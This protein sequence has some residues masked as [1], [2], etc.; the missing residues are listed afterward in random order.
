VWWREVLRDAISRGP[1]RAATSLGDGRSRYGEPVDRCQLFAPWRRSDAVRLKLRLDVSRA[2]ARVRPSP[3]QTLG[4]PLVTLLASLLE[5]IQRGLRFV[6][7]IALGC[8]LPGQLAAGVFAPR[9]EP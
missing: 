3:D 7:G 8:E 9:K 6:A 4:E 5:R 1:I 2:V